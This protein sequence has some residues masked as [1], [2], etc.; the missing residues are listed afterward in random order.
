MSGV[1]TFILLIFGLL[2]LSINPP[3]KAQAVVN[4]VMSNEPG[5]RTTLEWIEIYNDST[6]E[7]SMT[8][9]RLRVTN[10]KEY[11]K[12]IDL[13]DSLQLDPDEYYLICRKLFSTD[14]TGFESVWGN[15]SGTWGDTPEESELK[16]P[17]AISF[18]L[19]ND[20]GA[21]E[22]YNSQGALTSQLAWF[23][24]GQDGVSWER[25]TPQSVEIVQSVDPFGSTPGF[26]NS[27]T[28]VGADLA[29][30]NVDVKPDKGSTEITFAVVN[31]G[32]TTVTDARLLLWRANDDSVSSLLDTIDA[33][34]IDD[35]APGLTTEI[36]RLYSLDGIYIYLTASLSD[37]DRN[38]NNTLEFVA[39][40]LDFPPLVLSELLANP[41]E[42]LKT[43]WIE[44]RNQL[45]TTFVFEDWFFGDSL[46]LYRFA[47]SSISLSPG[48]YL[49]IAKDTIAFL[50]LYRIFHKTLL[51]PQ[52]WPAFNDNGDVVRLVDGFGFEA[53]RFEY[54]K[55][56]QDNYTWSRS[57]EL[58]R[59]NEWG[60]SEDVGGTPGAPNAVLYE[61]SASVLSV[62]IDPVVFSPDNDGF[63]DVTFITAEAPPNVE[64]TMKVYD[65]KGRVVRT[66][67]DKE[68]YLQSRY[69]WDGRSDAGN[70]LPIGIYI[71]Y[72]EAAGKESLKKPVVI[73]R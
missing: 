5:V 35:I 40:G 65:R 15:G 23:A 43:E 72:F 64:L 29:L 3:L 53:D 1:A 71:L 37:D 31:R 20:S 16:K 41:Q 9:Y 4:E 28:P 33:F 59:E 8:G 62:T 69:E 73:A 34:D 51:Q 6:A 61:P 12:W 11:E 32:L 18:S 63:D 46:A 26:V 30:G 49:V 52:Q 7:M 22:L 2:A 68:M 60:R 47:D 56:F 27:L 57:E 42:P 21:V 24:P 19:A 67:I 55:T 58:G 50:E 44:V 10:L 36:I 14:T 48:D 38:R 70:R 39:T 13:P 66:I 45:D 25:T 17:L 54:A